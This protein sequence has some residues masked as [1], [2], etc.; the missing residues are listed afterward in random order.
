[1]SELVAEAESVAVVRI[2]KLGE[3]STVPVSAHRMRHTVATELTR[4][5]RPDVQAVAALLGHTDIRT[6][7]RYAHTDTAQ[8]RRLLTGL[9]AL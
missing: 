2:A 8:M 1:M 3:I 5:D 4:G 7:L 6:T 9:P